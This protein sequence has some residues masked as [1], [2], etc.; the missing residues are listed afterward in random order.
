ML[1][2]LLEEKEEEIEKLEEG[3]E[4]V[5]EMMEGRNYKPEVVSYVW[6]LLRANVAH[7][8]IPAVMRSSLKFVGKRASQI[9]T[10]KTIND[11]ATSSLAASQKHL[12]V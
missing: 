6:E 10:V 7:H 1:R 4:E 5:I 11:M 12:E 2:E 9:P 8:Q 3:S